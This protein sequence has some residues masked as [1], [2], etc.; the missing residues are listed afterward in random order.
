MKTAL[1]NF[2]T[3][4]TTDQRGTWFLMFLIFIVQIIRY[5]IPFYTGDSRLPNEDEIES[6]TEWEIGLQKVAETNSAYYTTNKSRQYN[7]PQEKFNPNNYSV[8]DWQNLGFTEKEASSILKFKSAIKG[9]KKEKDLEKLYCMKPE[10]YNDLKEF[11]VF[12]EQ[13]AEDKQ[14]ITQNSQVPKLNSLI[15]INGADSIALLTIRGIGPYWAKRIIKYRNQ[16]GGLYKNEQLLSM[17]GFPDSLFK[18]I[19]TRIWVDSNLIQKIP[20]NTIS[21]EQLNKH[22]VGWYGVGKSIVN[23]RD[24]HGPY[25]SFSDFQK[26]YALSP[27]KIEILVHYIKFE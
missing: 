26:L 21:L 1:K 7:L 17:K 24:Q 11:L 23:Y 9:F 13:K 5:V 3:I 18:S 6:L 20:I 27:E 2:L 25:Q 12:P 8:M 19:Q 10:F 4:T 22:P 14:R 16:W 15:E